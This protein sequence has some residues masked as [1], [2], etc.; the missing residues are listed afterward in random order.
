[1]QRFILEN[2]PSYTLYHDVRRCEAYIVSRAFNVRWRLLRKII[3]HAV[4]G[5]LL[6]EE[7]TILSLVS[8]KK[9]CIRHK[10]NK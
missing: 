4:I 7:K 3:A 8:K 6:L 1:M 2:K 5:N 9:F 10:N